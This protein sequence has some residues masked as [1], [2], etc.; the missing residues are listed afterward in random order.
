[1][2]TLKIEKLI[3][4]GKGLARDGKGV[5]YFVPFVIPDETV[6]ITAFK[7]KGYYEAE[8]T[9]IIDKSPIRI[10]PPCKYFGI[11]GGCDYQYIPYNEQLNF[12][13]D[14][15]EETL[16]R[17]GAL[18][19]SICDI[20]PSKESF[21]YRNRVQLKVDHNVLGFYK[22]GSHDIVDIDK[23]LLVKDEIN[24]TFGIIKDFLKN[25]S[26]NSSN[27]HIYSSDEQKILLTFIFDEKVDIP[28]KSIENF[29]SQYS[30]KFIGICIYKSKI[31][32]SKQEHLSHIKT[33]G[34]DYLF[35]R[36]GDITYRV[37]SGD[38]FQVNSFQVEN[39]ISYITNYIKEKHFSKIID[40]YCGVGTLTIPASKYVKNVIG[41]E[42]NNTAIKDANYN[43]DSNKS[44][45][46]DFLNIDAEKS[47]EFIEKEQP[48]SVF[49]D[50]P[51]T[52]VKTSLLEKICSLKSLKSIVY[53]SCEPP[54]LARDLKTLTD[55]GF[56]IKKTTLLDMFPQT[57]HIESITIL[58]R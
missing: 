56:K 50:P 25:T 32:K 45:N 44:Y 40:V 38:F 11:C 30:S 10:T 47:A 26:L 53:V 18:E 54:I 4:G 55:K 31:N 57:Y 48:D 5:I 14:I 46:I 8:L 35:E 21:G 49:F 37:S 15:L 24:D 2:D 58:E 16:K 28:V 29:Y 39:L 43:K 13:K 27:I 1:M 6:E 33:F 52:G 42:A 34:Q 41:I 17:V 36:A 7:K 20:I 51:R 19:V 22:R 9:K 12:K 23:C 3:Y